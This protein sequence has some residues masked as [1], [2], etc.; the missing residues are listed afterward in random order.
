MWINHLTKIIPHFLYNGL[1][2]TGFIAKNLWDSKGMLCKE[3]Q[4]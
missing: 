4:P 3:V 2:N 1:Y